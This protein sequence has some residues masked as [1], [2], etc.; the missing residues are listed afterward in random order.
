MKLISFDR[1]RALGISPEIANEWVAEMISQKES[2]VLPAK[3]SMKYGQD[4]IFYNTMPAIIPSLDVAGVK[5]VNRYPSRTPSLDS[6]LLLYR[7]SSGECLA[8]MDANWITAMRTGA[9]AAHSVSLL[10]RRDFETVGMLG[11]GN[12]A[13]AALDCLLAA[14]PERHLTVLLL[15]YKDQHERFAARY[16]KN[17]NIRFVTESEPSSLLRKSDVVLSAATY[18]DKDIAKDE[19][20]P[21]GQLL[22]PIHTRGFGNCDLFFDRVYADDTE[23]VCDF[24]YFDRF[25]FF[26]EIS[27]VVCGRAEGRTDDRE[28]IL[29]YNI[30]IAMHD[31][32]FAAKLYEMLKDEAPTV[33]LNSPAEKFWF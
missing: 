19:D 25:R 13:A 11:L 6:Q 32:Y 2:S 28:R 20:F 3:I 4:G 30:G 1:I 29:V 26:A 5:L 23:H 21:E 27:D 12:V 24:R 8:C 18:F 31:V 14:F 9:V 10:A 17:P 22:V 15:A 7:L 33:A 16:R